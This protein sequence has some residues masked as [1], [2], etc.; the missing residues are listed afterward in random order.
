M[1]PEMIVILSILLIFVFLEICFTS[2]FKKDRQKTSDGI[3]EVIST[4]V[5]VAL[6][7]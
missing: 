5:L 4:G 1:K 2:F 3:V 6:S 7:R